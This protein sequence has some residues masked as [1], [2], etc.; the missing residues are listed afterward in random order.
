[1]IEVVLAFLGLF[2]LQVLSGNLAAGKAADHFVVKNISSALF[3]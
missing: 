2:K 1:M 3:F